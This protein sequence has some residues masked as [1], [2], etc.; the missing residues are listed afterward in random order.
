M[1]ATGTHVADS[2]ELLETVLR[3]EWGFQGMIMSDWAIHF[4]RLADSS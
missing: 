4:P 2:R 1:L 3:Q